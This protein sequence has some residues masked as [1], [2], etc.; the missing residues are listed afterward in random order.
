MKNGTKCDVLIAGAGPVGMSLALALVRAGISVV[1]LEQYSELSSDARAS[2]IH[3]PTLEF[4]EEL[5]VVEEVLAQGL[6]IENLQFWERETKELVADFPYTLIS[7][8]TKYP[9]RLQCPQSKVTRIILPHI[10]RSEFG[11][12]LFEHKFKSF[13]KKRN[14][15]EAVAETLVGTKIFQA[16]YLIGCD[17]AFSAVREELGLGFDGETYEDRFLLVSTDI[18]LK[19]HF[20]EMGQVA[21]IFDPNEWVIVMALA[22]ARRV[23]FRLRPEEDA[24]IAK[25]EE[26]VR[27]RIE[28]FVGSEIDY[29]IFGISTYH[30]HRRVTENFRVGQVI[31]AGDAAHIN[32]P[33]GGMGMNSGVHDAQHLSKA[34]VSVLNDGADESVLDEYAEVRKNVATEMVQAM[35][36]KSY[37]NL[38]AEDETVRERRNLEMQEAARDERKARTY[39]LKSAMLADRI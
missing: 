12:V 33:T 6:K 38:S 24:D 28:G 1:V 15:I 19:P 11:K 39:L 22:D 2:T 35:A 14:G 25:Q 26:N 23:V 7:K 36:D 21:Y 31:L 4:F 34:L 30:V 10:Q 18:D 9:C 37:K 20:P 17:G 5:G 16:K 13:K 3:P 27:K 8:D 29:K 32:N